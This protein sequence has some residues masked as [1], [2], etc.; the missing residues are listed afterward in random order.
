MKLMISDTSLI[1]LPTAVLF[2]DESSM[3]RIREEGLQL[4]AL[5]ENTNHPLPI[6]ETTKIES[7]I[8]L[9]PAASM[10]NP[11]LLSKEVVATL[12]EYDLCIW[13]V[14][15]KGKPQRK[16]GASSNSNDKLTREVKALLGSWER[17]V[18]AAK[19]INF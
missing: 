19:A 4:V 13:A 18:Q 16:G 14:T 8:E 5:E 9:E 11:F 7:V 15:R 2:H 6:E 1:L 3:K 12:L 10:Q 17:E